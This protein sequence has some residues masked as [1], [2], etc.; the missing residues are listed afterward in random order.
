MKDFL[1]QSYL[2]IITTSILVF[3]GV[4]ILILVTKVHIL[5]NYKNKNF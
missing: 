3:V 5:F 4:I 1:K 2:F